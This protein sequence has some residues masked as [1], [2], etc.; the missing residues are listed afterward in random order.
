[1]SVLQ[2]NTIYTFND[3]DLVETQTVEAFNRIN[4]AFMVN[5]TKGASYVYIFEG[6]FCKLVQINI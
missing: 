5:Y 2:N 6:I 4:S 1:M 3:F